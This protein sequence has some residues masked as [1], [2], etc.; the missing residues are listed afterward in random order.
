MATT[1]VGVSTQDVV[2][3]ILGVVAMEVAMGAMAMGEVL[4]FRGDAM[5]RELAV[6]VLATGLAGDIKVMAMMALE[7]PELHPRRV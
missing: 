2:A 5:Y 7:G 6:V 3:S 1:V 4:L